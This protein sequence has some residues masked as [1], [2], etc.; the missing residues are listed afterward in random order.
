MCIV[1]NPSQI[2]APRPTL[3]CGSP[4][5]RVLV[6]EAGARQVGVTALGACTQGHEAP[7]SVSGAGP[8][9]PEGPWDDLPLSGGWSPGGQPS[10]V[11]QY[12]E[13]RP[14][15]R[16][17]KV[18]PYPLHLHPKRPDRLALTLGLGSPA[19]DQAA[20]VPTLTGRSG[21]PVSLRR[22]ENCS[23]IAGAS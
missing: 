12:P 21:V 19:A 11:S 15:P 14:H 23:S 9:C 20:G 7:L 17:R 5:Y 22:R 4:G 8:S 10:C 1:L 2:T 6:G 3:R 13:P 18:L 16:I